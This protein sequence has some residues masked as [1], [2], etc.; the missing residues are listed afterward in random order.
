MRARIAGFFSAR[1][2][3]LK[4]AAAVLG[5][6]LCYYSFNQLTGFYIPCVFRLVTGLACPG[7]G[8]SHF[9]V[10]LLHLD[11]AHAVQQNLAA[12]VLL[13]VWLAVGAV[14]VLFRPR[15][16]HSHSRFMAV[17][18]WGSLALLV[19]F[20]VLRNLPGF[21]FLLPLYLR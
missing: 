9:F 16:L 3:Q 1:R 6:G 15:W 21:S 17:L 14:H 8:I 13:P 4:T 2:R 19:V 7:C 20:G 11:F 5:I 18:S 12:A 10:D